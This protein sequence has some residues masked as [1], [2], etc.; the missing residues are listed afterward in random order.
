MR[1]RGHRPDGQVPVRQKLVYDNGIT[2][3]SRNTSLMALQDILRRIGI[4]VVPAALIAIVTISLAG[5]PAQAPEPAVLP[6]MPL[7]A[8]ADLY[9]VRAAKDGQLFFDA[10]RF[11]EAVTF[12]SKNPSPK[13]VAD[14]IYLGQ[15]NN[16]AMLLSDDD[17]RAYRRLIEKPE[18]AAL[19]NIDRQSESVF[20]VYR[21]VV[22][23][24]G[25]TFAGTGIEIVLHDTRNPLKSVVAIQNAITGRRI[26]DSTTN[27]GLELI[28]N[29]SLINQRSSSF[30]SYELTL[31]DGRRIKS[32]TIPLYHDLWGLVGF[33]CLNIDISRLNDGNPE[34][35]AKFLHNFK[36]I[37][38]SQKVREMVENARTNVNRSN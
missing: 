33:I 37:T 5:R 32:S 38:E 14:L 36:A 4:T 10:E 1:I 28:R 22:N 11:M 20:Q 19:G 25:Q 3:N 17:K 2:V 30:I 7:A 15:S 24:I 21:D 16:V 26:G 6:G 18:Y 8:Y 35:V 31:K 12:L 23:G 9:P 13:A 27:F 34:A 29:Y